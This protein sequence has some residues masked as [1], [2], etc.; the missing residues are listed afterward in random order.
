MTARSFYLRTC[1][2]P[3]VIAVLMLSSIQR[4]TADVYLWSDADHIR[5]V[6]NIKPEWWTDD[7]DLMEPGSVKAP[8]V[9]PNPGKFV[10]DRENKKFHWPTCEQI[11]NPEGKLAIP[12]EKQIWFQDFQDAIDQGYY[13]CDH[14][15]PSADGPEYQ[16]Q[17]P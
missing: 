7:M 12:L 14:C 11:F 1:L 9:L 13:V 4:V 2:I 10:G 17:T 3:I 15:K 5:H 8:D 16:P 6:S